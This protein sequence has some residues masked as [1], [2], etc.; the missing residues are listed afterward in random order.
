M[1]NPIRTLIVTEDDLFRQETCALLE[2]SDGVTVVGE[3]RDA[4]RAI[5]LIRE[6]E[7]DVILLD[8]DTLSS[9]GLQIVAQINEMCPD[10]KIIILSVHSQEPLLLDAFRRGAGGHL[11]KGKTSPLEIV[12]AIR[13]VN[14]GESI[15]SPCMAGWIL[16]ELIKIRSV[17]LTRHGGKT[18]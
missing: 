2:N 17:E 9:R 13:A 4:Q 7:P 5:K 10:S 3:A 11:V 18:T 12:E 14:R 8:V 15:L 16:D 1:D 6:L